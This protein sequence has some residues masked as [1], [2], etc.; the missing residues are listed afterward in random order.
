M[1]NKQ[2][3]KIL[4][5]I[6]MT[7]ALFFLMGYHF[8]GE[9]AHELVGT[10]MFILFVLHQVLNR[11]WYKK[12]FSGTYNLFRIFQ[13]V[14]NTAVLL[15]MVCMMISG[16]M[17]SNYV[18]DFLPSFGSISFARILHM[19]S[20]YWGFVLM[21]F[22]LGIHW[23]V[24][25]SLAKKRIGNRINALYYRIILNL[26]GFIIALYGCFVL[27]KRSLINYMFVKTQFVFL[28]FNESKLLFYFDYIAIMGLFIFTAHIASKELK[29][30][31][32]KKYQKERMS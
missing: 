5:D 10:T 29:K 18:F 14:V 31:N 25:I 28:D 30:L 3:F 32:I 2:Q 11:N 8:W 13:L 24:F 12:L 6:L 16:I 17:L 7:L 20:V 26:F 22:H 9:T 4:V 27:L 15:S 23:A 19:S 1:K 21:S